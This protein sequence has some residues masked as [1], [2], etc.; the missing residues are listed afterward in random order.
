VRVHV[1]ELHVYP[2]K[3]AR[4]IA[5]DSATLDERGFQHDRRWM[6]IDPDGVFISQREAHRMALIDVTMADDGVV[7]SAPAMP[8]LRIPF[9]VS[10]PPKR[11]RI[12]KDSVD[13]IPV[14]RAADEWFSTFLEQSCRLVHMPHE[15]RRIVDR[16]YVRGD[17]V[18]GFADAYPLLLIGEGSL[19][20]LN[21]KLVERGESTLPMSRFRPNIVIADTEPHAEDGWKAIRIGDVEVDVVKP[22][23]R[24]VI[25]TV[26]SRT[27]E[28]GL[29]P[30]RTLASY[31]KRD[32]KVWFGQNA[33]HRSLGLIRLGDT[34]LLTD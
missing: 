31:R 19:A 13:A 17:R 14:S 26:D 18:V 16:A 7:V 11:C 4:G 24:C 5:L 30:L 6:L 28:S 27:G 3:S 21:E 9:S 32:G 33:V 29:E 1:S 15:T 34:V 23:A 2:I 22:C 12:W 25:T 20:L 10:G 8:A